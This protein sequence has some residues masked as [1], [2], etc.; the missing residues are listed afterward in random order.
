MRTNRNYRVELAVLGVLGALVVFSLVMPQLLRE[1][2]VPQLLS[3]SVLLRDTDSSGW[4]VARQGMEQAAD[5]L[6]AELRFLTLSEQNSSAEQAEQLLREMDNGAEALLVVPADPDV[7]HTS[8]LQRT[9]T[10]PIVTLESE[11]EGTVGTVAP[12]SALLGRQLAQ[13]LLDDWQGGEVLLLDSAPGCTGVTA[14]LDAAQ[15]VLEAQGVPV[16]RAEG[17]PEE[18]GGVGWVIAF[19]PV[20]T[21]AAAERRESEQLPFV[22][23]G[24]GSSTAI[25]AQMEK[26]NIAAVAAW[27]DYAAGYLAVRQAVEAA[28]REELQS[29]DPLAFS[30]V[31]GE[32]IYAPENQKLLFP[33]M[34]SSGR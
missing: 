19:D 6:G 12:D 33:I 29:L 1:R 28:Q 5:E 23:Y 9:K 22:L 34:S 32:D 14:R 20:A 15:K 4:N 13:T 24:V 8:L 26:G 18:A 27:S 11:M 3:L 10:C 16:Q 2:S 17:L 31:Q 21:Q 25:A 7:L 30:I